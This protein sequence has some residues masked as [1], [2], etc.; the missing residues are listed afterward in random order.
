MRKCISLLFMLGLAASLSAQSRTITGQVKAADANEGL[1]GALVFVPNTGTGVSTDASGAYSIQVQNGQ[2]SLAVRLLGFVMQKVAIGQQSVINFSLVPEENEFDEVVV[3][4][5]GVQRKSDLTGSVSSLRGKDITKVPAM[6]PEQALQGKLAG[7]QVNNASGAPGSVPVVRIRGVGT[8]NNAAPIYVVD[9]VILDDIS[10]LSSSDI[11]SMEI[12]KDA[13]ATAIYGSRGANGVVMVTTRRGS[14]AAG[15]PQITF[16]TELSFQHLQRKIDL[17]TAN[18]FI[19]VAT[20]ISPGIITGDLYA[21][22][23]QEEVFR[24]LSPMYSVHTGITGSTDRHT[25]YFGIGYFSQEGIVAK[26]DYK[27]I[28]LKINDSYKLTDKITIGA[29]YTVSP[30]A[31]TNEAGV[32]GMLYRAWP[33]SRP[34]DDNGNFAEVLGAGNPL[35][36]IEYNNSTTQRFRGVGNMYADV[37]FL[38]NFTFRSSFGQDYTV[39]N[40]RSFSPEYFISSSQSNALND[41]AVARIQFFTWLWENTLSYSYTKNKHHADA[42]VGYT[43]QKFMTDRISASTQDL[44]GEDPSL[45]YIQA[46]N[47]EFLNATS[48]GEITTLLSQLGRV[49]YSFDNR[50]LFTASIRRDGSS[51]FGENNRYGVF[52]SLAA[53]WNVHNESFYNKASKVNRIKLRASWGI[54]GNERIP[55]S[56]QYSLIDNNQNA[57][58]NE[59]VVQGATYGISGNPDLRWE[60]TEQLD[61]GLELGFWNDKLQ[62]ELDY[63][64]KTT[65]GILVDLLTPGH[66]GN[67]PFARVTYNAAR[68]RNSGFEM[69][70]T[71]SGKMRAIDF[72]LM[73]NASTIRNEVLQLGPT[74]DG[75]AFIPSG[76]LGNGQ[77]ASRTVVGNSVGAFF[78]YETDGVIQNQDELN[79]IAVIDG[80]TVGDLKFVDQNNDGVIDDKDRVY[81]GSYI[82]KVVLGLGAQFTYN[83]WDLGFDFAGQWGNKIYNAKMAVRPDFYN[84]E[85]QV[86]DAWSGEGSSTTE[87]RPTFGGV[88]YEVS[89][90]F[91]QDG[92]FL[93]LRTF[94]IGY[95]LKEKI[96]ANWKMR[97][98]RIYARATNLF[99]LSRYTGYTPEIASNDALSSGIDGGVYPLT[100]IYSVGVQFN[101]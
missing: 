38:K 41:L 81:L 21:T 88:N 65:E 22:N 44:I 78:G 101:F 11:E 94:S 62:V 85:S 36:A 86:L 55:W 89:D 25:Y 29:N 52:P 92:S 24:D 66:L 100:A 23:W 54:I 75:N 45:W 4:G 59:V 69:Q 96:P 39:V 63:Y 80:Q 9:G 37:H 16:T 64:N 31:K 72:Q 33:T 87:P 13:S 40:D 98:V 1:I 51:K 49:N 18:E 26:S 19:Q 46:G 82:P 93:R 84:F 32:I 6:S 57:V 76:S 68:V 91:I 90:Y 34:F 60:E 7:V 97:S 42:V 10:F 30:D 35:A 74:D 77:L 67:G 79:S 17:L 61:I 5:Y 50:Y 3:V 83:N 99:T 15:K 28:S 8:M 56:R 43:S 70:A 73:A 12:L 95:E 53:G 27:R 71:Y 14:G 20:Q 2:D 47:P 58:F 48:S